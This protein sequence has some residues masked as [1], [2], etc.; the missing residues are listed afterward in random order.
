[1]KHHC[2]VNSLQ[3]TSRVIKK[4]PTS[5]NTQQPKPKPKVYKVKPI[6][7]RDLVQKL[8]GAQQT[9]QNTPQSAAP[10]TIPLNPHLLQFRNSTLARVEGKPV[11]CNKV[12]QEHMSV[13]EDQNAFNKREEWESM[14]ELNMSLSFQGWFDFAMLSPGSERISH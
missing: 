3:K 6:H 2:D 13:P 5:N 11:L 1:M 7:F 14:T 4:Q 12:E 9:R 10:P 8:T